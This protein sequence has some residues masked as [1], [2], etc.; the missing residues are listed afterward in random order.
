[1]IASNDGQIFPQPGQPGR[2]LVDSSPTA[3]GQAF[4]CRSVGPFGDVD[5]AL[6]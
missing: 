6:N 3:D 2:D 4:E 1:M 5:R